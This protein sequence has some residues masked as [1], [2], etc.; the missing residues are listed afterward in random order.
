MK[1]ELHIEGM[2]CASCAL[3][4]KETLE[5]TAGVQHAAVTFDGQTAHIE[6]D[7]Q[8]VQQ[9]TLIQRIQVLGYQ[10]TVAVAPPPPAAGA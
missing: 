2:H 6:F 5:L 9:Q 1:T 10:A 4:I 8:L 7:E 3:D